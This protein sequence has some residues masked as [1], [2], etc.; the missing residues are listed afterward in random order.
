MNS[1]DLPGRERREPAALVTGEGQA[2]LCEC[3]ATKV[4]TGWNEAEGTPVVVFLH[5]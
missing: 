2:G 1:A 5:F 3:Y 4:G